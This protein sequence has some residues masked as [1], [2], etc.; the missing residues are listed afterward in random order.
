MSTVGS[1]TPVKGEIFT[2]AHVASMSRADLGYYVISGCDVHQSGTPSMSVA[3]D[4]GVIVYNGVKTTVAGNTVTIGASSGSLYRLDAIYVDTSGVAQVAPGTPATIVPGGETNFLF[5]TEPFP[6]ISIPAGP[7]LAIVYIAA[8][9]TTIL[10][11]VIND[12]ASF[13][14]PIGT[15]AGNIIQAVSGPKLPVIDGSNL[16][17]VPGMR[18]YCLEFQFDGAGLVITT[19]YRPGLEVPVA[20]H[21]SAARVISSD[22]ISGSISIEVYKS[23]YA[24]TP[25]TLSLIDTYGITTAKK[26]EETGLSIAVAVGDWITPNVA[27][28]T[29]L[30]N[31]VLSMT[32]T[33]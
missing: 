27:S 5:F 32:V 22:N 12:I 13:G 23:T 16:T 3:V 7:I 30:K 19:G 14:W 29:S 2:T 28:C 10:N 8:N 11:A 25:T 18:P 24:N 1:I 20:G 21:I 4:A 6:T 31:V 17:L 26:S 33:I 9:V 15:A